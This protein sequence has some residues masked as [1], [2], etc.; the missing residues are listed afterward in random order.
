MGLDLGDYDTQTRVTTVIPDFERFMQSF[1]A[2]QDLATVNLDEVLHLW[3]C[4]GNYA[5]AS[6]LHK[7]ANII[8]DEYDG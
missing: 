4:L 8:A 3:I 7:A 5:L 6:N 1:H 2:V